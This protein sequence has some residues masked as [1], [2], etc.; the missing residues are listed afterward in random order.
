[1]E[2]Q[3]D[4]G[5]ENKDDFDDEDE[6]DIDEPVAPSTPVCSYALYRKTTLGAALRESLVDLVVEGVF[7]EEQAQTCF[8]NYDKS[9]NSRLSKW[10]S[11]TPTNQQPKDAMDL[12]KC[13]FA[14][15]LHTYRNCDSVWT[16]VLTNAT[17]NYNKTGVCFCGEVHNR[18]NNGHVM[19]I[20]A[21]EAPQDKK[22]N[23]K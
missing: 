1:M 9:I 12:R 14:G 5:D 17:F 18:E 10:R 21:C 19:K 4:F 23:G 13:S 15:D 8:V 2:D 3:D 22:K 16:L 6:G 11:K 7:T 20:V